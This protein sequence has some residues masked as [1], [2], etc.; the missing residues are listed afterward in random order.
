MGV[1]G[2]IHDV[3]RHVRR[4]DN[5][6][7]QYGQSG[8]DEPPDEGVKAPTLQGALPAHRRVHPGRAPNGDEPARLT[9]WAS[10]HRWRAARQ[11]DQSHRIHRV[12]PIPRTPVQV[13]TRHS[14]RRSDY[15]DLLAALDGVTHR[16][17]CLRQMEVAGH[18]PV[19]DVGGC[20]VMTKRSCW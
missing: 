9:N 5:D 6:H 11:V 1:N 12:L 17:H 19:A 18:D 7:P 10:A 14:A 13:R 3:S 15:P 2:P 16:D 20:A 4:F 8:C